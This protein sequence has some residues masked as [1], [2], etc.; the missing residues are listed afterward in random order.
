MAFNRYFRFGLFFGGGQNLIIFSVGVWYGVLSL[1][2]KLIFWL[3][4]HIHKLQS[5]VVFLQH[6]LYRSTSVLWLEGDVL[7]QWTQPSQ[8]DFRYLLNLKNICPSLEK[9]PH[10]L[11]SNAMVAPTMKSSFHCRWRN[12]S[13]KCMSP[14][15]CF[16][17]LPHPLGLISCL[18]L[19]LFIL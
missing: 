2:T 9:F 5:F 19:Y 15:K 3:L 7:L 14:F 8:F 12:Q 4:S 1:S 11:I 13:G 17:N 18:L 6:S 10:W 16:Q